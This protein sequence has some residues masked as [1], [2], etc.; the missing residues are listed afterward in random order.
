MLSTSSFASFFFASYRYFGLAGSLIVILASVIA[1][2]VYSGKRNERY[3]IFNHFISELGEVG[4]SRAAPIFNGGLIAGGLVILP[5]VI[6]LGLAIENIW[7]KLGMLAGIWSTVSC[8]LVGIFP[9]NNLEPH[10]KVS[11]SFFRSG[12]LYLLFFSL[13][14]FFQPAGHIA[15]PRYAVIF[16]LVGVLCYSAFLYKMTKN[17]DSAHLSENLDPEV[18]PERPRF[19]VLATL[20]WSIFFSTMGWFLCVAWIV[21]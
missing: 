2:I 1:A 10:R 14:I 21:K 16:G 19:W 7:A 12:L 3:S 6:G 9:M 4:V 11:A 20:E 8:S 15:V 17:S 18:I 5:F 13:G